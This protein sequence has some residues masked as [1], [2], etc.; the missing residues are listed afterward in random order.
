MIIA[1]LL[2]AAQAAPVPE[3]RPD[4][5]FQGRTRGTGTVTVATASRPR[6]LSVAGTGR[7][8]PDGALVLDQAVTLDGKTSARSFRLR[9]L[10]AGDWQ[11]TLTDAAGP[12]RASVTGNRLTI[13]YR[14]KRGGMRMTQTLDLQPGGRSMTNIAT[15]TM[16]GIPVARIAETIEKLDD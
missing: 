5:F 4:L 9:R 8:E 16:M 7:I 10:P 15:V 6:I 2:L 1:T 12:V 11:G 3:F 14:M 13:A